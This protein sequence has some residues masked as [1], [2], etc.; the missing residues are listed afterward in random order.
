MS[1]WSLPLAPRRS[2]IRVSSARK[3]HHPE[4]DLDVLLSRIRQRLYPE[5]VPVLASYW[6][7]TV[8]ACDHNRAWW[9]GLNLAIENALRGQYL[10]RLASDCLTSI[11]AWI[12]Q[13]VLSGH[14]APGTGRNTARPYRRRLAH[15]SADAYVC[16][17]L[18]E[19]LSGELARVLTEQPE[20]AASDDE[21]L[22]WLAAGKALEQ[23]LYR[24]RFSPDTLQLLLQPKGLSPKYVYPA[25]VEIL[26]DVLLCLLG[27]V[28][29][30]EP[31]V[32][33][34]TLLGIA[35]GSALPEDYADAVERAFLV[36]GG[37]AQALHVP[38]P[39]DQA[40]RILRS[41]P[42]RIGSIVVTVDGR[43]WQAEALQS[44]AETAVVYRP[45]GRL[46]IDFSSDHARLITPCADTCY[47][48]PGD[49]RLP[50]RIEIFGRE[51]RARGWERN[52]EGAWLHLEFVRALRIPERRSPSAPR[53][54]PLRPAF[55]EMAWS[56]LEQTL[57]R[58]VAARSQ[59]PIDQLRRADLIPL[60]RAIL[61][62]I[63]RLRSPSAKNRVEIE[64]S[65]ASVRYLMGAVAPVYGRIPWRV[66]PAAARNG[67]LKVRMDS[68]LGDFI[69]QIFEDAPGAS[70]Q[71][72]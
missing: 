20:C 33:P 11:Q 6:L 48:W 22:P 24:E 21:G 7:K 47:R 43:W 53:Q 8:Y 65:L 29:A 38:L 44:G 56:E 3:A 10:D 9:A 37:G 30:P 19:S 71:A 35:A 49:V 72:A 28:S 46:R 32:L 58:C 4:A 31:A 34:A 16:R 27:Q 54:R 69:D 1:I 67:I 63:E 55:A 36:S 5:S 14:T 64:Q 59:D 13:E 68:G 18:N 39:E 61:R 45:A 25:H 23:L 51:W 15:E 70:P 60:A 50:E 52:A 12:R 57:A 66:V 40:L 42:V 41:D 26:R 62:L 2:P 17:L